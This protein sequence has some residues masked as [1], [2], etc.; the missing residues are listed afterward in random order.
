[1]DR[2]VDQKVSNEP[3]RV[4]HFFSFDLGGGDQS[5]CILSYDPEHRELVPKHNFNRIVYPCLFTLLNINIT[6]LLFFSQK[7]ILSCLTGLTLFRCH[8]H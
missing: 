8:K 7:K 4:V 6:L 1:M 5:D 2:F 3:K